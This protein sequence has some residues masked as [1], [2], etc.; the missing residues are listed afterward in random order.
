M[1]GHGNPNAHTG[2]RLAVAPDVH[3]RR[4]SILGVLSLSL[5]ITAIDH[6]IMNVALPRMVTDL[7]AS[8]SQRTDYLKSDDANLTGVK[9]VCATHDTVFIW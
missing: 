1:H 8:T 5:L 4:W 9:F 6:T 3:R 2:P 7:G